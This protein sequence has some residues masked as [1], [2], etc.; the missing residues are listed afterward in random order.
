MILTE[1]RGS[2]PSSSSL[3]VVMANSERLLLFMLRGEGGA[4]IRRGELGCVLD[5]AR[6]G[7]GGMGDIGGSL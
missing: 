1:A 4:V 3:E 5:G 7:V 6:S 2:T